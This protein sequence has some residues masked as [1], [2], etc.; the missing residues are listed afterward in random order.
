MGL[1]GSAQ[2]TPGY[3]G[4]WLRLA[5]PGWLR[6]A[7]PDWLPLAELSRGSRPGWVAPF[8]RTESGTDSPVCDMQ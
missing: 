2:R 8:R 4:E 3:R 6:L 5:E 1:R 7:A